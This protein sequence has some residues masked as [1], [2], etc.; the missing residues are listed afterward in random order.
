[1]EHLIYLGE[2]GDINSEYYHLIR[3][4]AY[5]NEANYYKFKINPDVHPEYQNIE[6][7]GFL[8]KKDNQLGFALY[9][10][11]G[12]IF[13]FAPQSIAIEEEKITDFTF[14]EPLK[15]TKEQAIT[16]IYNSSLN[17]NEKIE[18]HFIQYLTKHGKL[19]FERAYKTTEGFVFNDTFN[20]QYSH[21]TNFFIPKESVFLISN[22]LIETVQTKSLECIKREE[23][24]KTHYFRM[25]AEF[26]NN[27][28]KLSERQIYPL[29]TNNTVE[30]L[31]NEKETDH[32]FFKEYSSV[33]RLVKI[34]E[35]IEKL[36][37]IPLINTENTENTDVK[38]LIDK[39]KN[40]FNVVKLNAENLDF[41]EKY[42]FH[43]NTTFNDSENILEI[44]ILNGQD[45]QISKLKVEQAKSEIKVRDNDYYEQ[46]VEVYYLDL[47]KNTE[48]ENQK[49]TVFEGNKQF[50]TIENSKYINF[51]QL[52]SDKTFVPYYYN[53]DFCDSLSQED[54]ESFYDYKMINFNDNLEVHSMVKNEIKKDKLE[55]LV[56][57]DVKEVKKTRKPKK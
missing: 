27:L 6:F 52:F 9:H 28:I 4:S 57:P 46:T 23:Y 24:E 20:D 25:K 13:Q 44:K 56:E 53:E 30:L 47:F 33:E 10:A 14:T 38:K 51:Y 50:D 19:K 36:M 39:Y 35:N 41:L 1:M 31:K 8:V 29:L 12:N 42:G 45:K 11:E 43:F 37:N 40:M 3:N 17:D 54:H 55:I 22:S 34:I 48:M 7:K 49:V 16:A 21:R 15:I 32:A 18:K 2:D 26:N 5:K